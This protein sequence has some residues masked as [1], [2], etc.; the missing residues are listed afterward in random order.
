[1][2]LPILVAFGAQIA[3]A[4]LFNITTD[5]SGGALCSVAVSCG[6]VTVTGTSTLHVAIALNSPFG[7]FGNKNTFG[8][9]VVGTTTGVAMSNFSNGLFNG[10]GGSGNEDGWG[11]YNFRVDGPGGSSAVSSLS[12]DVTRTGN[13]FTGPSGIEAGGSGG[14][15]TTVFA[16]HIRNNTTGFTGFAG[17][18]GS[19]TPP[20]QVPEPT[21][22]VLLGTLIGA[23]FWA[24]KRRLI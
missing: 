1:M 9:N 23:S 19:T 12:F 16:M 20:S 8:F 15:G 13:P 11:S 10:N 21:S 7:I 5:N 18:S 4:D 2:M 3:S 24:R 22:I 14:N 17:V 6:T